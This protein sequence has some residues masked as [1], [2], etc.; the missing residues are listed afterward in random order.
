MRTSLRALRK[1]PRLGSS[2]NIK[3]KRYNAI[4]RPHRL[5]GAVFC[6]IQFKWQKF[7]DCIDCSF[8]LNSRSVNTQ[9]IIPHTFINSK[10]NQFCISR[11]EDGKERFGEQ[12][13]LSAC[14]RYMVS[15]EIFVTPEYKSLIQNHGWRRERPVIRRNRHRW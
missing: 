6:L 9:I 15:R 14:K 10:S 8:Y 3:I 1:L 4:V 12:N 7:F 11:I 2:N 13:N 5:T